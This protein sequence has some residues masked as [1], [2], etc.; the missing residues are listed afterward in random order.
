MPN[1]NGHQ[2]EEE[3]RQELKERF[4]GL[5]ARRPELVADSEF[6]DEVGKRL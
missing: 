6:I 2:T 1:E 4:N 5:Q 3:R